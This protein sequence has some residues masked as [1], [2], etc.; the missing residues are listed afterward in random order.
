MPRRGPRLAEGLKEIIPG[1]KTLFISGYPAE[2]ISQ[3]GLE[4]EGALLPKPFSRE[5]LLQRVRKAL[6]AHPS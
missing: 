1:L 4:A 5:I 3:P 2:A 6:M